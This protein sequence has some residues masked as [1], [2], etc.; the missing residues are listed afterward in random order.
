MLQRLHS[1]M[2]DGIERENEIGSQKTG[3]VTVA[4]RSEMLHVQTVIDPRGRN[5]I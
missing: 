5:G 1:G 4:I 2:E 3:Q